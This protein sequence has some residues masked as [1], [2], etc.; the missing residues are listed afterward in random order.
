MR[1]EKVYFDTNDGLNLVGLLHTSEEKNENE[2]IIS[3]HGMGSN[4]LKKRDDV[5]ANKVTKNNISYFTFNNR[6]M[7][8]I[9]DVHTCD[10]KILQGT[11]FEDVTA[12]YYDI[13]GAIKILQSRGYKKIHLQGHSLG[14]T[15]IVYMYNKLIQNKEI[16]ILNL[17]RSVILLSLVD[18]VDVVNFL[19][20]SNSNTDIVNLALEKESI[21]NKDYVIETRAPF[22]PYVSVKTFLKYYRD[23]TDINFARYSDDKFDFKEL[24]NISVPLFMRWGNN[25][26]LVSI[27]TENVVSICQNKINNEYKDFSYIDGATH[28][29][30]GKE[31]ILADEIFKFIKNINSKSN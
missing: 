7:G 26:E 31:Q 10:G 6:G 2:V 15:K 3:V 21:G 22:M 27:P 23:N 13:V 28:N 8:I 4:C 16:E 11:V 24:N 29:Y 20:R 12:S 17:I 5:I 9:N 19:N 18:V 30:I 25:K 1:I 14:S